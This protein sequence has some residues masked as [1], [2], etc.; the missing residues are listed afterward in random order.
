[1]RSEKK[2]MMK[3]MALPRTRAMMRPCCPAIIWPRPRKRAM[4]PAMSMKV[5]TLF[6]VPNP[7]RSPKNEK[8]RPRRASQAPT[9]VSL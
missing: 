9:K 5:L 2:Y 8:A 7:F 6:M 4:R 3:F 1:M